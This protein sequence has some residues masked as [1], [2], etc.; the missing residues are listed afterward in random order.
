MTGLLGLV[1]LGLGV[2]WLLYR[3]G[4]ERS[5]SPAAWIAVAWAVIYGSR[6]VTSWFSGVDHGVT[7]EGYDEGNPTEALFYFGL[8]LAGV[9]VLLRR[10]VRLSAIVQ[11]HPWLMVFWLF[12]LASVVWSDYPLI[13]LK[14][15]VKDAGNLIVVL[16]ILTEREPLQAVK[17]VFTRCAY[18]CIP[19]SVLL[20]RHFPDVGRVF[21][22]YNRD[23]LMYVGVATHKN[24]LGTLALVSGLFLLWDLLEVREQRQTAP[25]RIT[26]V[27]RAFTL[28]LCWYL[29]AIANS[30]T[31]LVS[32]VAGSAVLVALA[33]P[34][35]ARVLPRLVAPLGVGFLVL[36][37][38]FD[39]VS[40][41]VLALGRDPTLTTRTDIWPLL[42]QYQANPLLGAGFNT[43]WAGHRLVQLQDTVGGIIQA[44]NGYLETYLSGGVIGI[45][46]LA[47][48]LLS[49]YWRTR[50]AL[51]LGA[52]A[53]R[54]AFALLLVAMVYNYAEASF[55][56]LN[57]LWFATVFALMGYGI[58]AAAERSLPRG[59]G[60]RVPVGGVPS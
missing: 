38:V 49:A 46:L 27:A 29:L 8:L 4:R 40:M 3:D 45:G 12:W 23:E 50:R 28:A 9:L 39:L 6:P 24:S 41:L 18:L 30:A 10:R 5:V 36:D 47:I 31:S 17:A 14:R 59:D 35:G 20:I 44:H 2:A 52:P 15:W 13:T 16:V 53:S 42:V 11:E 51:A 32:A 25:A 60:R 26:V 22:G 57:L 1:V 19:L 33:V 56:K 54:I 58:P 37:A 55:N 21:A 43:F 34:A 7:P 48:L